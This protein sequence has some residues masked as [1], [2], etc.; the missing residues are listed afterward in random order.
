MDIT[1][2]IALVP[3]PASPVATGSA[4]GWRAIARA[5]GHALPADHRAVIGTYGA[6]RF[7]D[8]LTVFSPFTPDGPGNLLYEQR[9][10]L[11]GYRWR[12]RA[13]PDRHLL[14]A[15]PEPGGLLPFG[16]TDNGD[17]L[18]WLTTGDPQRW[19]VVTFAARSATPE[20]FA[21]G[22]LPF[23]IA[24]LEGRQRPSWL[25]DDLPAPDHRF[26]PDTP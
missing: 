16:R 11:A 7:D 3:P 2:L 21:G 14:P 8:W 13:F 18:H 4:E 6:G 5:I 24:V 1:E 23:L 19:T 12:R 15:H 22:L 26:V 25:P 9:T 20:P 10:I 17:E